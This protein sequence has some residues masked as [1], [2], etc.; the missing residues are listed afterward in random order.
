VERIVSELKARNIHIRGG[1]PEPFSTGFA[2]TG[3]PRALMQELVKELSS[4]LEG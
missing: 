1:W 2:V 4:V 3:G